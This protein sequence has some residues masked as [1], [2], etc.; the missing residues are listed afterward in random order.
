[1]M[2]VSLEA[3]LGVL[4]GLLCLDFLLLV[5]SI[6]SFFGGGGGSLQ[7]LVSP[8]PPDVTWRAYFCALS[9]TAP[10]NR[11]FARATCRRAVCL[12]RSSG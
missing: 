5:I 11:L 6:F 3:A 10:I 7:F 9:L 4:L 2:D 12:P 8:P 1:M